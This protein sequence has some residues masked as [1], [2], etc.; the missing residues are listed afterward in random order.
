MAEAASV[1]FDAIFRSLLPPFPLVAGPFVP[2]VY[3]VLLLTTFLWKSSMLAPWILTTHMD[4]AGT[5]QWPPLILYV[6]TWNPSNLL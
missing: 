5:T 4:L 1:T 2:A 3:N 6:T